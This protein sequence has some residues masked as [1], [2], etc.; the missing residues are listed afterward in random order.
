MSKAKAKAII[1]KRRKAVRELS[2]DEQD[3]KRD[4]DVASALDAVAI[5]EGGV[6]IQENLIKDICGMVT[7]LGTKYKALT[8]IELIA[9]CADMKTKSDLL[10]VLSRSGKNKDFLIEQLGDALQE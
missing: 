5:S 2:S 8:H 3:V 10:H 1:V 4:L 9:I 6:I 7:T